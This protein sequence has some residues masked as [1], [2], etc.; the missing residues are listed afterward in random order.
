MLV[1][2]GVGGAV[3]S[4]IFKGD[5]FPPVMRSPGQAVLPL[6]LLSSS[7]SFCVWPMASQPQDQSCLSQEPAGQFSA[8]LA[9]IFPRFGERE[10]TAA[11]SAAERKCC[12]QEPRAT[13]GPFLAY[14]TQPGATASPACMAEIDQGSFE[15]ARR[16]HLP[17]PVS[18][19]AI[20]L[21]LGAVFGP[22]GAHIWLLV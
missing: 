11:W 2:G 10:F 14:L 22:R 13:S 6:G 12:L 9:S 4:S 8:L 18:E 15:G 17:K 7:A 19:A 1:E 21:R 16:L 3:C 5:P 20:P